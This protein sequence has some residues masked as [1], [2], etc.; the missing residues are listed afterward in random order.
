VLKGDTINLTCRQC[1]RRFVFARA[2][3]E[4]YAEKGLIF[5]DHCRECSS[6]KQHQLEYAKCSQC[7]SD[8]DPETVVYCDSCWANVCLE[9]EHKMRKRQKAVS[10]DH[11][12]LLVTE[13]R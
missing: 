8:L 11:T 4:L 13:S 2:E 3:Q 10:K 12:K 9:L 6:M 1:G 5:P 7:G